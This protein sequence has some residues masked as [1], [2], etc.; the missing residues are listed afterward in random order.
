M[1]TAPKKRGRGRPA[2]AKTLA[3]R[4]VQAVIEQQAA[5]GKAP[6]SPKAK[7]DAAGM[8][9][10][11]AG[12]LPPS[13]G[14][15]TALSG[16]QTIRNRARDVRRNDWSGRSATQKWATNLVGVGITPRF[17]RI[18]DKARRQ[19]I[20]DLWSDF[21][22]E[23]DADGVLDLYGM[24]T[25]AVVTWLD[26]GEVFIRKR[27]RFP[28]ETKVPVQLQLLEP[29]YCPVFDSD[30]LDGLP[31]NNVIRSGIEF[32]KRGR[33][34]A[35]WFYKGH[36]GD[37]WGKVGF[38]PAADALVRVAA[39]EVVHMF[40]PERAGQIR[41][42]PHMASV[43]TRLKNI[44]NYDD[45]T[46]TRMQLSNLFAGF[47]KNELPDASVDSEDYDPLTNQELV[48]SADGNP[49]VGL[50]PGLLQEL[51]PG[52]SVEFANPP[53]AGTTYS[54]YMRTAH[55]GT[56][57]AAGLPYEVFSG[58]IK[59]VSDRTLRVLINEFRRHAEQRQ[60]QVVIPMMCQRAVEWF[61]EAAALVGL[62]ALS[63]VENVRRVKH[64]P[65]GWA[66]IHPVQDPQGKKLEVEA[67]FRSRS[68]VIGERGDDPEQV[69]QERADDMAREKDLDL[70]VDPNPQPA[71]AGDGGDQD[72]I[73]NNEYSAP[74]NAQ[75]AL[76]ERAIAQMESQRELIARQSETIGA[77]QAD[78]AALRQE[79]AQSRV[80]DRL[81]SLLET[82]G[83][84]Q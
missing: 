34:V 51:G 18:T 35:Y 84:V 15:N 8:G 42:V 20:T 39:S 30:T 65:H 25:L 14:P 47:I 17:D 74:P 55:M 3:A 68:S 58:D 77:L 26:G 53:E 83:A 27:A 5:T 60:W 54:D 12:W 32:N 28:D 41:G 72:G 66:H 64:S 71:G 13:S 21:V 50:Q 7:Y 44:E 29:E 61:T 37:A 48:E 36:P 57:A 22:R 43:L 46:L 63:E 23:A 56:A 80:Q 11:L 1:A 38:V 81:L 10:R 62:I 82:P 6:L 40:E 59:E 69:D 19:E 75:L 79:N 33:R 2:S 73:D 49:L 70:W 52:Q 67:G 45:A 78:L 76:M 16:L 9:R 24:Q 31:V 4:A